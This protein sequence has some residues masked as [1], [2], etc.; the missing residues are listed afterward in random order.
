MFFEAGAVDEVDF[1]ADDG[2]DVA[3]L[4]FVVEVDCA[5]EVSVVG[6]GE[7]GHAECGGAFDE[8]VDA[9]APVEQRAVGVDMKVNEVLLRDG[10][11]VCDGGSGHGEKK[12]EGKRKKEERGG[13]KEKC[14]ERR[15]KTER[16]KWGKG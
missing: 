3:G 10:G 7:G 13:R 14:E 8:A 4:G 6:D 2:F 5:E 11:D 15:G 12:E 9:A 16:L 1:A